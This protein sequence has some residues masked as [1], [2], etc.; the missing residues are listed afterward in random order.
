MNRGQHCHNEIPLPVLRIV[1]TLDCSGLVAATADQGT[2][3]EWGCSGQD[4]EG[5]NNVRG[6]S[7]SIRTMEGA[8]IG[9][10]PANTNVIIAD[11]SSPAIA[12]GVCRDLGPDWFLPSLLEL[13]FMQR[14][15]HDLGYGN[16]SEGLYWSS[17]EVAPGLGWYRD[18]LVDTYGG[19]H[20]DSENN[21]RA[22][23][24]F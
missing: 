17:T 16:F 5:L 8:R 24:A 15:L 20:K 4:I 13:E 22:V 6:N 12:A 1:E 2:N 3:V 14:N 10:G 19:N 11:C 9:D 23:R 21:V 7:T 18:F